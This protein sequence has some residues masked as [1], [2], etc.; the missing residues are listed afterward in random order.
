MALSTRYRES[1]I[2]S[3]SLKT[4]ARNAAQISPVTTHYDPEEGSYKIRH[5]E[6]ICGDSKS[7]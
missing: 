3:L 1:A 6:R 4:L 5:T 2:F 7:P